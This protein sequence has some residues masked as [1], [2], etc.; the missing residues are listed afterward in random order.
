MSGSKV[1]LTPKQQFIQAFFD[2]FGE[3]VKR[4]SDLSAASF[5]D[6]AFTLCIVY[7]DWL[8]S[9]YY[10]GVPGLHGKNFCRALTELSGNPLFGMIHPGELLRQ[11]KERR[12]LGTPV[13]QSIVNTQVPRLLSHAE[14]QQGIRALGLSEGQ[15]NKFVSNLWRA[16]IANVVYGN[17][18]NPEIHGPG[19]GGLDLDNTTYEGKR[20]IKLNFVTMYPA[21]L[22]IFAHIMRTSIEKGEWFGRADYHKRLA[23]PRYSKPRP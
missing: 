20:G 4:L 1:E 23:R 11:V 16:S 15:K 7:I 3:R 2:K 5:A 18:R 21:L 19:S 17:I 8:A 10:G 14:A 6:E 13:I 9:G 22:S 12:E